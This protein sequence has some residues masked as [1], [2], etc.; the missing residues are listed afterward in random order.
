MLV[1]L[2]HFPFFLSTYMQD[3]PRSL[4]STEGKAEAF[5]LPLYIEPLHELTFRRLALTFHII[6]I[7]IYKQVFSLPYI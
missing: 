4:E 5:Y 6:N 7:Y 3:L 1:C 2:C